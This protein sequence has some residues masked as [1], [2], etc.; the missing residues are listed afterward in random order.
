ML[1][2]FYVDDHVNCLLFLKEHGLYFLATL[3]GKQTGLWQW[4]ILNSFM[5]WWN[6]WEF[7]FCIIGHTKHYAPVQPHIPHQCQCK[8]AMFPSN[9]WHGYCLWNQS[10]TCATLS[11]CVSGWIAFYL[12]HYHCLIHFSSMFHFYTNR[13][14]GCGNKTFS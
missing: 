14:R 5:F 7:L 11:Y 6:G 13:K 4:S 10:W 3:E 8:Y 2:T 9:P 1:M 12:P